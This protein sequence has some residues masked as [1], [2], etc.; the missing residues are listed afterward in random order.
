MESAY[1][2]IITEL[3]G[4]LMTHG[5]KYQKAEDDCIVRLEKKALINKWEQSKIVEIRTLV[6]N[7]YKEL[8]HELNRVSN[9]LCTKLGDLN[10]LNELLIKLEIQ[11]Q[12]SITKAKKELKGIYINIFD[13]E[14]GLYHKQFPDKKSFRKYTKKYKLFY[15]LEEAKNNL[16]FKYILQ[17]L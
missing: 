14:A 8:G 13:L 9:S 16:Q 6:K 12:P 1:Q 5:I 17:K 2:T 11:I 3:R 10:T 15:P 4:L 7:K